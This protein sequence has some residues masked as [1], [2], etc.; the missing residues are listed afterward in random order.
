MGTTQTKDLHALPSPERIRVI[1]SG[2]W[3]PY[4]KARAILE[5]LEYIYSE[6]P[7][8]RPCRSRLDRVKGMTIIGPTNNGKTAII[9]QFQQAIRARDG[10][11]QP[12]DEAEPLRVPYVEAPARPDE[13]ALAREIL[14]R[15]GDTRTTKVGREE[16]WERVANI[17]HVRGVR[18]LVIDEIHNV[19]AGS[20][21]LMET[22]LNRLKSLGS[23]AQ[24]AVVLVGTERAHHVLQTDPEVCNRFRPMDL[25]AWQL[26]RE[27]AALVHM[28][29]K[30]LPLR[31]QKPLTQ[32]SIE[33]LHEASDGC[34]GGVVDLLQRIAISALRSGE[35]CVTQAAME[36]LVK[37]R[38]LRG[39]GGR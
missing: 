36:T 8:E 9:R 14:H 27:F 29:L 17:F 12:D 15:L 31:E 21:R 2:S 1:Q 18:L 32:S 3:I 10:A 7:R 38:Q 6:S 34:L 37:R 5:E 11:E 13:I 26:D 25:P 23:K 28:V 24:T 16:C 19:L 39:R 33:L 35:E 4:P 20:P 30:T 22:F